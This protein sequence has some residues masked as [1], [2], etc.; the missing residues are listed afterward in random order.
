MKTLFHIPAKESKRIEL[1]CKCNARYASEVFND[2]E[3][4]KKFASK[5]ALIV[6]LTNNNDDMPYMPQPG[7]TYRWSIDR[8]GNDFWIAFDETNNLRFTLSCRY[9]SEIPTLIALANYVSHRLNCE[10]IES[11]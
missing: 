2:E 1:Q 9:D 6:S 7:D 11:E 4:R 10:I 8:H 5:I 3:K